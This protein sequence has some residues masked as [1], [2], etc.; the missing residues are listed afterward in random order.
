MSS[1]VPLVYP[2]LSVIV[3]PVLTGLTWGIHKNQPQPTSDTNLILSKCCEKQITNELEF[4]RQLGFFTPAASAGFTETAYSDDQVRKHA[5]HYVEERTRLL[6]QNREIVR[7]AD[8]MITHRICLVLNLLLYTI[9]AIVIL[10]LNYNNLLNEMW[11]Y[12]LVW[13]G[14]FVILL[15]IFIRIVATSKRLKNLGLELGPL[16]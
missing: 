16:T 9:A 1:E 3:F 4:H 6:E 7:L 5:G 10:F 8:A 15:A 12:L 2:I 13:I 11:V 14:P